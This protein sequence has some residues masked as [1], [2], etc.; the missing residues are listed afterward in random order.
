MS[1]TLRQAW[2]LIGRRQ[3]SRWLALVFLALLASLFEMA[4]AVLVYV[5]LALVIDPGG[6][7]EVPGLGDLRAYV[8]DIQHSSLLLGVLGVMATFFA[9]RAAVQVG[10]TYLQQRVGHNTGARLSS[11]LI[12][13]YLRL[14]YPIHLTRTSA[15]LIRNGHQAVQDVVVQAFLP[16]IRVASEA[17]LTFAMLLVLFAIAPAATALAT[18]VIGGA[19]LLLLTVVQPR[20]KR[21]GHTAHE[22]SRDS[23]AA[24]QQAIQGVRDIKILAREQFFADRYSHS[25]RRLAR[26][27]YLRAAVAELPQVV[28]QTALI[29]FIL[30]F[31]AS[32]VLLGSETREALSVLGLFGYVGLRLQPS[33]QRIVVGLNSLKYVAAPLEEI[34]ADLVAID[35][36]QDEDD[37]GDELPFASAL[38][39]ENVGFRYDGADRDALSGVNLAIHP[40]EVIGIC[41]PTGGGKTTLADILTGL[42][43]PTEGSVTVDGRD[44]TL[45]TRAWQR[46]LGVVPQMVFLTDDS[47][48]RNIALGLRDEEIDDQ[49][50]S[51]VIDLAQLSRFVA[52]LPDGLDATVGERGLRISGGERQRIAIA[53]ALYRRP[54]VLVFDEGTSALD[55]AT[56]AALVRSI[57]SLRGQRTIILI[58]HRLSTVREADRVIFVED[59]RVA[60]VDS[61]DHLH[62]T[63]ERFRLLA[64]SNPV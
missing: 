56:E 15:D 32:T 20:L 19:A 49:S 6:E 9:L 52:S 43:Q 17:I 25:R 55:N 60:G 54:S 41:G 21:I 3:R 39:L 38:V 18:V 4:G 11:H 5:L 64:G 12:R 62:R 26:S 1:R 34:H 40:G 46:R 29:F 53:R 59:G 57:E 13:G 16:I 30:F 27:N 24:V 44:L 22:A 33:L 48:R 10:V 31:F 50:L 35:A 47:L 23:L 8:G 36:L 14:P 7:I 45:H 37:G 42:Q 28:M 58:A 2:Q 51:E 61:F 63:N